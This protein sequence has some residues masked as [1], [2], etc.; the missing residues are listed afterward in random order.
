MSK[1]NPR[2]EAQPRTYESLSK[3]QQRAVSGIL[4]YLDQFVATEPFP[5]AGL[6]LI[7]PSN[8]VLI[9]GE[10]GSGKTETLLTLLRFW[11]AAFHPKDESLQTFQI[12]RASYPSHAPR[13]FFLIYAP[14]EYI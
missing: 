9:D 4:K 12:G 11:D 1:M 5:T 7:R 10:R 6:D 8:V 14:Y 2:P 3:T 13:Q